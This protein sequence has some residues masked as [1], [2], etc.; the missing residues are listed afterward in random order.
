MPPLE[1]ILNDPAKA[2]RL[3]MALSAALAMLVLLLL[4]WPLAS[5]L[6]DQQAEIASAEAQVAAQASLADRAQRLL[7]EQAELAALG[8]LPADYLAGDSQDQAAAALQGLLAQH[9]A[10][11]GGQLVSTR[12]LPADD[13]DD[14]RVAVRLDAMVSH[15]QLRRLLHAVEGGQPRLII[16]DLTLASAGEGADR[17]TLSLTAAG[18]HRQEG[19]DQ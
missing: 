14:R 5:L 2:R 15:A 1:M 7:A 10:A 8:G 6:L 16:A 11:A 9:L 19:A 13:R 17:L 18:R 4:V 3:H 12:I